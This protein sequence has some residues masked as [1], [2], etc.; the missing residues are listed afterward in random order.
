MIGGEV[1]AF[2]EAHLAS[3]PRELDGKRDPGRAGADD[4]E[5]SL[6][7][8]ILQRSGVNDAQDCGSRRKRR[9]PQ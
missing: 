6:E 5:V 2:K 7:T 3:A 9:T 8:G 1:A 4:T